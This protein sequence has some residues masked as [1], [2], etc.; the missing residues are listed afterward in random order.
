MKPTVL[1]EAVMKEL[2]AFEQAMSDDR[3]ILERRQDGQLWAIKRG[4]ARPV[5]VR[6]CFPWSEP[7]DYVS[8]RDGD[9][10]EF[11][12]IND[13][14]ELDDAS[15]EILEQALAEAGFVLEITA[16][17]DVDEEVE[18]RN[19]KV[20]TRQGPRSF[21][22]RLDDWP[23]QVPSGGMLIRDVAGDLYYVKDAASLDKKSRE[24]LWAFVD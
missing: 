7:G 1:A 16:I 11:A 4:E 8:L 22:T 6:R 20:E 2:R 12:L 23:R 24:L 13:P 17:M 19:W 10:G 5:S 18:I 3:I 21:Q 15:R 14:A 9:E